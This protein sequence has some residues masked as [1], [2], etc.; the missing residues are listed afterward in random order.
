MA[1]EL[2]WKL[3]YVGSDAGLEGE[4]TAARE[5]DKLGSHMPD[6]PV[7]AV[8]VPSREHRHPAGLSS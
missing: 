7:C 6:L 5:H 1:R 2:G 3:L 4:R 8:T